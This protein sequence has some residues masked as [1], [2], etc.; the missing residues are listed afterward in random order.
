[1]FLVLT[2][3]EA[4]PQPQLSSTDQARLATFSHP[5]RRQE[6]LAGRAL[7]QRY[8]LNRLRY[9]SDGKPHSADGRALSLSHSAGWLALALADDLAADKS[10]ALGVD[11]EW[12][13]PRRDLNALRER[14]LKVADAEWQQAS[15]EARSQLFYLAWVVR[16]AI[17][18]AD[19]RGLGWSFSALQLAGGWQADGAPWL[20][21]QADIALQLWGW[22]LASGHYLGCARVAAALPLAPPPLLHLPPKQQACLLWQGQSFCDSNYFAL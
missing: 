9:D 2:P 17:A 18:K 13:R 10:V 3:V 15:I 6:F 22:Q 5:Q 4:L 12:P 19:G 7:L 1:V 16:E 14:C 21:V 11:L 8:G 20:Q